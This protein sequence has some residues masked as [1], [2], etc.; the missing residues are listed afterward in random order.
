MTLRG[1]EQ[2]TQQQIGVKKVGQRVAGQGELKASK[3]PL[4]SAKVE[5]ERAFKRRPA[6]REPFWS[7][8]RVDIHQV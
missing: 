1:D 5:Q 2:E 6:L 3:E 7:M 4:F 8:W